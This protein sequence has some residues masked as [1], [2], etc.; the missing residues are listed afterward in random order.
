MAENTARFSPSADVDANEAEIADNWVNVKAR[1]S[2]QTAPSSI[3]ME[4]QISNVIDT[5]NS[6]KDQLS[7]VAAALTNLKDHI[8][9]LET[10]MGRLESERHGTLSSR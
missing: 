6:F 7:Q 9:E 3:A 5:I 1:P 10:K 4:R 8:G 2:N